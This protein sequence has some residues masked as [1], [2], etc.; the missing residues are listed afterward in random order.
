VFRQTSAGVGALLAMLLMRIELSV[1]ANSWLGRPQR[2]RRA[3][4]RIP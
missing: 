4:A 2:D 1:G 3:P